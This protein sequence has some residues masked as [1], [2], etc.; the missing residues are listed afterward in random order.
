MQR[1]DF[2]TLIGG[3][4]A[5]PLAARA[6]QGER[7][8]R[9]GVLMGIGESDPEAKPRVEALQN[10]LQELGWTEGRN[11]HLEY[12]WTAGDLDLTRLFAKEIVELK[13]DV[14]VVHS[15]PAVSALRQLKSA[16]PMVFVLIADPIGSGF[17]ASLAHPGGNMT[18][19]MNVDAPMSGKWLE[20]IMQIAPKIKRVSLIFNPRTSPYQS[21]LREFD[22]SA[23]KF[24][25]Q[26]V[27]TPVLDVA[28]LERAITALGQE[29]DTALFVVPDVFVQ[30]HRALIIR[31][32]EQYR[33]PAI[34]PYRFFATSGGL[35]SY[36]IDTVIVF[37]QAASYVDR[38]LK[39]T[40]PADLPVQAP[41]F[42][43]LVIN[44]KTAKA[45]GLDVPP[46]LLIS[47]DE[48]IE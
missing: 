31:L 23:P 19:F 39:G 5:W 13:P 48:V 45:I 8:R 25:I 32:A 28:E 41:A 24:G 42:F 16:T 47:A 35:L 14:I 4:A 12:R 10:G 18:G 21:Y 9:I 46:A 26:A 44:L 29:P 15:T 2:I 34:Y 36:G 1:R 43:K 11:I 20:L 33:L 30:V 7:M 6:Q 22:V 40:A 37:R 27:A 17:V 38:I 3:A